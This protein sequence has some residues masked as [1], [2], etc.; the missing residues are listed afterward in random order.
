MT[1]SF[2]YKTAIRRAVF[3]YGDT[4]QKQQ[5]LF[6]LK[7]FRNGL[8]HRGFQSN[9]IET[10]LYQL[11][12]FVEDLINFHLHNSFRFSSL[13]EACQFLDLP[14]EPKDLDKKIKSLQA[15]KRYRTQS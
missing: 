13:Q 5:I 11:K 7:D 8:V 10:M 14:I 9:E 15:A 2:D 4:Q 12:M 1:G 3:L 6:N